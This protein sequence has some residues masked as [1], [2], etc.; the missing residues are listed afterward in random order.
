LRG[1]LFALLLRTVLGTALL[2]VCYTLEV[3]RATNDVVT[4]TRKVG[5]AAT[6]NKHNGVLLE[7]VAFTTDVSPDF[8]AIAKAYTS[9][10]TKRRVRLL[11]SLGGYLD[12]NATL[13][14]CGLLVVSVLEVV[15]NLQEGW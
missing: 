9:Y 6:T 7:V 13:E 8:L 12:A 1:I 11:W 15:D 10:F 5:N 2:A 3:E 4:Y 14:W